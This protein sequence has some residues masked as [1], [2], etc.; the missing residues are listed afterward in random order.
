MNNGSKHNISGQEFLSD[1][2]RCTYYFAGSGLEN[3][4]KALQN[5]TP[6]LAFCLKE[7][8]S[9]VNA[10]ITIPDGYQCIHY[11]NGSITSTVFSNN[12]HLTYH[13]CPKRK[14]MTGEIHVSSSGNNPLRGRSSHTAA[15]TA[16]SSNIELHPLPIC[17]IELSPNPGRI[18]PHSEVENYFETQMPNASFN[19]I[20]VHLAMKGYASKVASASTCISP[21]WAS[22]FIHTSMHAFFLQRI[23]RR[24]GLY[25][26][27]LCLQTA[28]FELIVMATHEYKNPAYESN[29]IKY[30]Y[31]KDYFYELGSRRVIE[32]NGGFF[33]DQSLGSDNPTKGKRLAEYL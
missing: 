17:R 16:S 33:V 5:G 22:I 24:P 18:Q 29:A 3:R 23:E 28:R 10:Y 11:K 7:L 9:G 8:D 1:L 19:T 20:E 32:Q 27:V 26:M 15:P 6:I 14:K 4:I 13:G 12:A 25:P 31:T 21:H 30:F 2:S